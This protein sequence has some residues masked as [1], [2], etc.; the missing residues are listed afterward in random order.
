MKKFV[1]VSFVG[2]AYF[3]AFL[4]FIPTLTFLKAWLLGVPFDLS[5]IMP[6]V[7]KSACYG[8]GVVIVILALGATVRRKDRYACSPPEMT[9]R[10]GLAD[11]VVQHMGDLIVVYGLDVAVATENNVLLRGSEYAIDVIVDRDG[12]SFIYLD[13]MGRPMA[14]YNVFLFLQCKRRNRLEFLSEK[15]VISRR[16]EWLDL[17]VGSL[18]RNLKT[19]GRDILEGSK[20]WLRDY[21]GVPLSLPPE[22]EKLL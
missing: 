10:A 4:I 22:I 2:I 16:D 1:K 19:A 7:L 6:G 14:G 3:F 12:V 5:I 13:T 15:P 21:P 18:A 8:A 11:A 9:I 20:D 17:E